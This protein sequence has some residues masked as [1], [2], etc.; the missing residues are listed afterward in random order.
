MSAVPK[1]TY[2]ADDYLGLEDHA[3]YRSQYYF[4]D[5]FAM[6][7]ASRRHNVIA[8]N[9]YATL[10][11]QLRNRRCEAYQ[12][13]MRVKVNPEFYTYPDVVIICGEP[14]VEKKN[15]ENL[16]NPTVLIEVLSPS[17]E[18]FDCGDKFRMYRLMPSVKEY[19]LS[20]QDKISAEHYVRQDDNSWLFNAVTDAETSLELPSVSCRLQLSDIYE[21]ADFSEETFE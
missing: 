4:G 16:L 11:G 7:G 8:G 13:N 19:I 9:I 10:H 14:Q 21:K 3:E 5:L 1:P 2:S 18:K 20:A 12:N 6:A 15:G 17:T